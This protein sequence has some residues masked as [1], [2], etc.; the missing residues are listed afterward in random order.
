MEDV[1]ESSKRVLLVFNCHE[2]WVYQLGALGYDLEIITGLEGLPKKDW[3]DELRPVPEN[4]RFITLEEAQASEKEYYCIIGHNIKDL[5]DI[6]HR[7][8]PRIMMVHLHLEARIVD[9]RSHINRQDMID[10]THK[11]IDLVGAHVV[12]VS[13]FKGSSWGFTEDV[14]GFGFAPEDYCEFTG[15]KARG[16][17]ISNFIDRRQKYLLWEFHRKAFDQI[18]V[19]IV[20]HNP[21]MNDV[22]AS[23]NWD[24]LKQKLWS[25]RFYIH[26]ANPALED[27]YNMATIEAMA[28][29]MPVL[30]NHHP[31]SPVKHGISGFLS[32]DPVEL[33]KYAR[34]LL[35]D[36]DLAIKMGKEG[37]RIVTEGFSTERFRR[38]FLKSIETARIKCAKR[39]VSLA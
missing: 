37:Q 9:E 7:P 27:G 11:Y 12:A 8:E 33:K 1:S 4:S 26:T 5:L 17:R 35:E 20:G 3:D 15:E 39:A 34:M 23:K 13:R 14:V 29:G 32:D 28:A 30:G 10:M 25:H 6:K 22:F 19:Q 24:D 31:T 2:S 36:R 38:A 21:E 18:P 16:L